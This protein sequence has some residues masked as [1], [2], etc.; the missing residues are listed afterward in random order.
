VEVEVEGLIHCV[1]ERIGG[2]SQL[3]HGALEVRHRK[4]AS[5]TPPIATSADTSQLL[6]VVTIE[7]ASVVYSDRNYVFPLSSDRIEPTVQV[8]VLFMYFTLFSAYP[9]ERRG[10][11]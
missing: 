5:G 11:G 7:N 4:L 8:H 1:R 3:L 2:F 9:V 6:D 10:N